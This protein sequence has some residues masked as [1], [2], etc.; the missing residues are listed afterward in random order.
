MKNIADHE[1]ILE[2][3]NHDKSALPPEVMRKAKQLGFSDK[4]IAQAVQRYSEKLLMQKI[5][6]VDSRLVFMNNS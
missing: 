5:T 2:A 3:Y 1:K 4:Q 6:T